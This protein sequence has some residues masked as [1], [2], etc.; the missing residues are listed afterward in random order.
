MNAV[1]QAATTIA[2][3]TQTL[4]GKEIGD[5]VMVKAPKGDLT[6]EVQ[7]IKYG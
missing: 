3:T 4:I 6:Y 7:D 1:L 5:E 2:K